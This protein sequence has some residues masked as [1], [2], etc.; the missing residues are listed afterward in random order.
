MVITSNCSSSSS[1]RVRTHKPQAWA[2]AAH[3][4]F[5]HTSYEALNTITIMTLHAIAD[6]GATSI[7]VMDGINDAN[8]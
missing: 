1:I 6:T 3:A 7:F 8:K 4:L 2:I 5:D